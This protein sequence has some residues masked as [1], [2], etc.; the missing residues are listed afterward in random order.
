ML[1]KPLVFT[2]LL[3]QI[4]GLVWDLVVHFQAGRLSEFFEAPHWPIFLGFVLLLVAVLQS[5]NTS[6]R[7]IEKETDQEPTPPNPEEHNQI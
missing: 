1:S 6:Q 4:I 7:N 5:G 3:F 2:A